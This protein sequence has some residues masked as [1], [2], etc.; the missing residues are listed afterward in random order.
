MGHL[1]SAAQG[2]KFKIPLPRGIDPDP[3]GVDPCTATE[4][5]CQLS[6]IDVGPPNGLEALGF[7]K[8]W[9]RT[10]TGGQTHGRTFDRLYKSSRQR[11]LV[12]YN[13][14]LNTDGWFPAKKTSSC[15]VAKR[16][17]DTSCLSVLLQHTAQLFLLLVTAASNL[18]VHKILLNSVLLSLIVSG[19]DGPNPSRTNT[20]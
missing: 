15:A 13:H 19:G 9:H 5:T 14:C 17:R 2:P 7:R 18:L 1:S 4:Y 8:C 3:A 20:P 11:W 16:P 6:L 12:L 10:R